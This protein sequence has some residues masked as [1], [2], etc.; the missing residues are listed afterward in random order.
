MAGPVRMLLV[1]DDEAIAAAVRDGLRDD[2]YDVDVE[3]TGLDALIALG[4]ADYSVAA[5]DVMLP[6]MD[7]F[8]LCRRI[9][10][11]G[12][13]LPVL[14]LTARDAV[15]DRVRG[16]DVGADD[17]LTKP[18]AFP[19]LAA[20]LR[21]LTRRHEVLGRTDLVAGDLVL[22][23]DAGRVEAAGAPVSLSPREFQLLRLLASRGGDVVSR[24]DAL[25][26]VWGTRHIEQQI[27]DQYIAYLRRKLRDA[28]S[29]TAIET[30][31]GQG[32]RLVAP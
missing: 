32:Y 27:V 7:G 11:S 8:E 19:E 5:V 16:L 15:E 18:F 30:V 4:R 10:E 28:G 2:G 25:D 23:L 29:A 31:R 14:M 3:T 13:R 1:E 22:R 9:R 17:Y 21:A 6:G 12:H 20:R 24:D 26:E